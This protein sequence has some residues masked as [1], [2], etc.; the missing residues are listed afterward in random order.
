MTVTMNG[1]S[2]CPWCD[3][4]E[5]WLNEHAIPF[6]K[7]LHDDEAAR[8]ALY[9]HLGLVGSERT[10]PQILFAEDG[11]E[12]RIGGYQALVSEGFESLFKT[13]G[14]DSMRHVHKERGCE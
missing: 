9:D 5:A 8:N 11:V 1:K 2:N 4:S 6:T 13:I 10:M 7:I 14:S 12:W 3:K